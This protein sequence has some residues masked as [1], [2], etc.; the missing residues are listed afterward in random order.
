[1]EY[2]EMLEREERRLRSN[3]RRKRKVLFQRCT[4]I[5]V[6]LCLI[7]SFSMI[8][9]AKAASDDISDFSNMSSV[10]AISIE[11]ITSEPEEIFVSIVKAQEEVVEV[12]EVVEEYM[13]YCS[14]EDRLLFEQIVSAET[15]GFWTADEDLYIASV[16]INRYDSDLPYF[17]YNT[18]GE[19]LSDGN[20]FETF[21]NGRYLEVE[22]TDAAREAVDRVLRGEVVLDS[23]VLFFCTEEYFNVCKKGD[24]FRTLEKKDKV[25]NVLFFTP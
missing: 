19:V 21:I 12:M 7:I 3:E 2:L 13:Y 11:P 14:N 18:I 17:N 22:V 15:Y 5:Y 10:T 8:V 24:F 1:M 6:A 23:D 20:Q 4:V 16:V 9:Y 25:R